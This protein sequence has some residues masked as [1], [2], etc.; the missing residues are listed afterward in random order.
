[1]LP[2]TERG[3]AAVVHGPRTRIAHLVH[4]FSVAMFLAAAV[5]MLLAGGLHS[6]GRTDPSSM[7]AT[8][9][10]ALGVVG[11]GAGVLAQALD[12]DTRPDTNQETP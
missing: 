3:A 6:A 5:A 12:T 1:M 8:L 4:V 11:I 7:L 10:Y 2:E 9:G